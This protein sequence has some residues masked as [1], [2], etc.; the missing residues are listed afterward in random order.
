[1]KGRKPL[2]TH[3]KLVRGTRKSRL[4][5]AEAKPSAGRPTPPAHLSDEARAEWRRVAP[6]LHRAGLLSIIDRTILAAYANP[7]AD[8]RSPRLC[9]GPKASW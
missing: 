5:R 6:D 9:W 3:L 8:G 1:M 7:T 2:P 4:N